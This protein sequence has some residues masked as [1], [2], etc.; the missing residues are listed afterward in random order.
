MPANGTAVCL[1]FSDAGFVFFLLLP[2][3][4]HL[5]AIGGACGVVG[6]GVCGVV[7]V[8]ISSVVPRQR[9][10]KTSN[11]ALKAAGTTGNKQ[12]KKKKSSLWLL[13]AVFTYL[14]FYLSGKRDPFA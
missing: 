9:E 6:G 4:F 3:H 13:A 2:A 7:G 5:A 11:K 14:I 1:L 10:N 8:K 12:T